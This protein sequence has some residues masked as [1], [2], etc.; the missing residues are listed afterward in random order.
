MRGN[1]GEKPYMCD[2]CGKSLDRH[3]SLKRHGQLDDGKPY[4]CDN[5]LNY[6]CEHSPAH[7]L[8]GGEAG[9]C[10]AVDQSWRSRTERSLLLQYLINTFQYSNS[11]GNKNV[12]LF[13]S[14]TSS[15]NLSHAKRPHGLNAEAI[16]NEKWGIAT[17]RLKINKKWRT[18][19]LDPAHW[20]PVSSS[21]STLGLSCH[22]QSI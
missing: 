2:H 8:R 4:R 10:Q 3:C 1:T 15:Y 19:F 16:T 13:S 20:A 22:W 6:I 7:C 14:H 5:C 12:C 18:W 21:V 17:D 9:G 11:L